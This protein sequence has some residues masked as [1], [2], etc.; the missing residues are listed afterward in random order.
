MRVEG[1]RSCRRHIVGNASNQ[2][3]AKQVKDH[4]ISAR[5]PLL[6]RVGPGITPRASHRSGR[7]QLRH[8]V[9][10]VVDSPSALLSV[11]V[12]LTGCREAM[13]PTR[14]PLHGSTTSILL[15]SP[16]SPRYRFPRFIG[17]MKMCDFLRPSRRA[18][19]PS[20]GDT[21]RCGLYFRSQRSRSPDRGP[22]VHQSGPLYRNYSQ[23]GVQDLPGS[24]GTLVLLCRVLGP[25]RDRRAWLLERRR[26]GPRNA[27]GEG[28][29]NSDLSRLYSTASELAV[30]ASCSRL[31]GR[32]A[33]LASGCWP[34]LPDGIGL[35]T[36]SHE[37]F[38]AVFY[39]ASPS[40]KLCLA[41]GR[42]S[43][44]IF[45]SR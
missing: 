2:K 12:T 10:P 4:H 42:M 43:F 8:P 11:E 20:L 1:E 23:G 29:H 38:R 36:G 9:R 16:G 37:R 5:P 32:H 45:I 24:W 28:S 39:I 6:R 21:L 31:P 30:Y 44:G 14:C 15:P 25:R 3:V 13:L 40:P 35:P 33:T 17:T 22:G 41:Q 18:S 7:A 19:L 27:H 26:H 34:A